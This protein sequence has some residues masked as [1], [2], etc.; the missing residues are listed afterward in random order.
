MLGSTLGSTLGSMDGSTDGLGVGVAR[1]TEGS[2]GFRLETKR[3]MST[4][5]TM[6]PT[7]APME[8]SDV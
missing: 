8:M 2:V 1:P 7:T 3:P 4:A 5:A 6:V